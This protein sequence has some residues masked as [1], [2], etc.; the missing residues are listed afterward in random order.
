MEHLLGST[1]F[2]ST[3]FTP[4]VDWTC[5]AEDD[6]SSA[7]SRSSLYYSDSRLAV[8]DNSLAWCSL[9]Y[10]PATSCVPTISSL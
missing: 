8:S 5:V 4:V 7:H 6:F 3:T 9:L 10:A 1:L 2:T